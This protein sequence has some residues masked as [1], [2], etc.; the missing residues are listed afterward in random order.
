LNC[1][2][3]RL[4]TCFLQLT[5]ANVLRQDYHFLMAR[6]EEARVVE[7]NAA[8]QIQSAWRGYVS[9]KRI[10]R[11]RDAAMKLQKNFRCVQ[12][13]TSNLCLQHVGPPSLV[14]EGA[15]ARPCTII[16]NAILACTAVV[17]EMCQNIQQSKSKRAQ[18]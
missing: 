4:V 6:A 2:I 9:R 10:H 1:Q 12:C 3:H 7:W 5:H 18:S 8:V 17:T 14:C 13:C 15:F 16:Y 11:M